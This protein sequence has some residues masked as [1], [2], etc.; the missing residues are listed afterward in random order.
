MAVGI[1]DIGALAALLA[2]ATSIQAADKTIAIELGRILRAAVET[3]AVPG[4][5]AMVATGDGVIYRQAV[6][7]GEDAI[8][9]IASMTKPVTS[10]AVMQL[11][12]A[13]KVRLDEPAATYLPDLAKVQVLESGTLR[14]PKS[15]VTVRQLLSHT[16]GFTY[17][18]MNRELAE[19]VR[20][21]KTASMMG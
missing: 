7:F 5:V 11:V 21:G 17:E 15:P 8:F 20:A 18:F 16:S 6:N 1:R 10:V 3:R 2:L 13:G 12:E 19:Y 4:V 14:S 9:S